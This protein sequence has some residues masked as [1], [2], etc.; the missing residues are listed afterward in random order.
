[1]V[2]TVLAIFAVKYEQP[3]HRRCEYLIASCVC[4]IKVEC[5]SCG[6]LPSSLPSFPLILHSREAVGKSSRVRKFV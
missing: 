4:Y 1:M 2:Q 3:R 5:W 6:R